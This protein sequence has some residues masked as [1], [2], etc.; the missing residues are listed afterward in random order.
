MRHFPLAALH[1]CTACAVLL[2]GCQSAVAPVQPTPPPP[3]AQ[4]L[5]FEISG[6]SQ[7]DASGSFSW[8]AIA[9]GGSGEYQYLWEVTR[10]GQQITTNT[11]R[12]LSLLVTDTDGDLVLRLTV[13]SGDQSRVQSLSVSN[14]I[15]GCRR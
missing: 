3:P 9:F 14:C 4:S 2:I 12:K 10:P 1:A 8:E 7:I 13:T 11:G 6:P 5:S 15:G